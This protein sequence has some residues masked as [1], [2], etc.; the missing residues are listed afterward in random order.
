MP[1][2]A[3]WFNS[4]Y[5]HILYKAHDEIESKRFI[6]NL[7]DYL[8]LQ[9]GE[10][11]LDL[12]CGKGRHAI[13]LHA[14]GMEVTGIDLAERNIKFAK[15]F[16]TK[17]LQFIK[18]DMREHFFINAFDL[19]VNLFTSFGYFE[20]VEDDYKTLNAVN[21]SLKPNGLFV[22]DFFNANVVTQSIQPQIIKTVDGIN[23]NISKE[24]KD[25]FIFKEIR[26][27]D[28]GNEYFFKERVRCYTLNDFKLL[29]EK[30]GFKLEKTFGNY[31]FEDFNAA[32]S[33]RLIMLCRKV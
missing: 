27:T 5:Y 32:S 19:V 20:N 8:K 12:A 16:E 21:G 3:D 6:V 2:F 10:K 31:L 26:F 24:V 33:E 14:L 22:L 1:W 13:F 9:K 25:G 7:I 30:C 4:P 15:K 29:F 28:N 17:R 11:V 23:F 18:G